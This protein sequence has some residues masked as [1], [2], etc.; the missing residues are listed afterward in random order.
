MMQFALVFVLNATLVII[1]ILLHYEALYHL[2]KFL[3][4]L[5]LI[6]PRYRV[7][8]GVAVIFVCHVLEIW[9]FAIGYYGT[10]QFKGMGALIGAHSADASLFL[11]CVYLSFITF[12]TVGYGDLVAEGYSR[13]LTGVEALTG[14][15]LVTWS[16]S[17]LFIEMQ[18]YWP[19]SKRNQSG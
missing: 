2:A 7:L 9:I 8:L 19:T 13:Y 10:L 15:V 18:K 4:N 11:D 5:K 3:P 6:A 12:T 1:T 14:L 16:A 17:F